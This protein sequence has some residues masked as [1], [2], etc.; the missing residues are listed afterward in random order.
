MKKSS[1]LIFLLTLAGTHSVTA[2]NGINLIGFGA[3]SIGM[4][5][6]DLAVARDTTAL[7]TNP[8]GLSQISNKRLDL[9][10][11]VANALDIRHEDMFGNNQT[12][13]NEWAN[14]ADAG[15]A[16][17]VGD[18]TLGIGAFAQGGIGI[19]YKNL[20]TAFGTTD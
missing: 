12:I 13:D 3:E 20:K 4:G 18:F 14:I 1:I 5:G 10:L 16:Q 9:Y 17:Q 7:N 6:A 2:T 15:Y 19:V 11:A 8:A